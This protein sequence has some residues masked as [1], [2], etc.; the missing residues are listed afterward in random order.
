MTTTVTV[1]DYDGTFDREAGRY[2]EF[3]VEVRFTTRTFTGTD[4]AKVKIGGYNVVR[5]DNGRNLGW[6][7]KSED[8]TWAARVAQGAFRGEGI[9]DQGDVLDSVDD[10]A[11]NMERAHV[12]G[13]LPGQRPVSIDSSRAYAAEGVVRWLLA[14]RAPALGFG[15]HYAVK[16]WEA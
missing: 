6:V 12:N 10:Y 11:I 4:G 2:P 3:S 5:A 9:D 13:A 1:T 7:T 16:R 8:G 15:R 14:R